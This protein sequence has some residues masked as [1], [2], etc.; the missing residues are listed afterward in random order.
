MFGKILGHSLYPQTVH[1]SC[2]LKFLTIID[3]SLRYALLL[4]IMNKK[5]LKIVRRKKVIEK[6]RCFKTLVSMPIRVR[7]VDLEEGKGLTS[8][9]EG[10]TRELAEDGFVLEVDQVMVDGLHIFTDSMKDGR[11]LEME[12]ELPA[13]GGSLQGTGRV[14]WFKLTPDGSPHPFEAAVLL[15]DMGSEQHGRWREFT[16]D[17]PD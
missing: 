4:N 3:F 7:I 9:V 1:V 6:G 5:V 15:K 11:A 17:L 16:A 14:L 8:W 13:A 12:W 2:S 10:S